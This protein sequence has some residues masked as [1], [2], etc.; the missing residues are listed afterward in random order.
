MFYK[1]KMEINRFQ[2]TTFWDPVTTLT[3]GIVYE[4]LWQK[5]IDIL[6]RYLI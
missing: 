4:L 3:L 1:L 2:I 6:L 5:K